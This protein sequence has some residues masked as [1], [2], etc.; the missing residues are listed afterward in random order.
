MKLKYTVQAISSAIVSGLSESAGKPHG[1]TTRPELPGTKR[2]ASELDGP[3]DLVEKSVDSTNASQLAKHFRHDSPFHWEIEPAVNIDDSTNE[4]EVQGECSDSVEASAARWQASEELSTFLG[5]TRTPLSKSDKR[6][7]VKDYP[8]PNL[9]APFTPR[10]DSY[11][12]GLMGGLTGPE[13][14]LREIQDKVLDIVGPLRT[15]HEHLLDKL[16]TPSSII[17]FSRE[18]GTGLMAI[19]Q[20]SIQ[21]AKHASATISQ[22]HRVGV[23]SKSVQKGQKQLLKLRKWG[24]SFFGPPLHM[25]APTWHVQ[26]HGATYDVGPAKDIGKPDPILFNPREGAFSH[27]QAKPQ[28]T[29]EQS[30]ERPSK[31]L[32]VHLE[33]ISLGVCRSPIRAGQCTQVI[34]QTRETRCG[35]PLEL[36]DLFCYIS[37]RPSHPSIFRAVCQTPPGNSYESPREFGVYHQTKKVCFNSSADNRIPGY[38]RGLRQNKHS[39]SALDGQ[40]GYNYIHQQNEGN[41]ILC[42]RLSVLQLLAVVSSEADNS[43]CYSHPRDPECDC[44]QGIQV[45]PGLLRLEALPSSVPDPSE[46]LG[47]SGTRPVCV[48]VDKP[49]TSLCELETR[50]PCRSSGCLL[51]SM[52]HGQE[53]CLL[54]LLSSRQVPQS[55]SETTSPISCTGSTSVEISTL[56]SPLAGSFRRLASPYS[57]VSQSFNPGGSVPPSDPPPTGR[58]AYL[59]QQFEEE[60]FSCQARELLSAAWRKNTSDQYASAWRKWTSW[61]SLRKINSVSVS[62]NNINNFLASEF[63]QGK[64]YQ[65]LNVY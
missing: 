9:D 43:V 23:L 28:P 3:R 36:G 14:K 37:G 45:S 63:L 25:D 49:V 15:A 57:P 54:P 56:V 7:M 8:R 1:S 22:K 10:L 32:K 44:R 65:T 48:S 27:P 38:V 33:E 20:R 5:T 60:G 11:L 50:P 29:S 61:C 17:Q 47:P 59:W 46:P 18:E 64:Q 13:A 41:Q 31:I 2:S 58:M 26:G 34:H 39:H 21:L 35:N 19:I 12:P 42:P 62:L 6:Q 40:F 53:L 55:S 24:N 16:D 51:P 4:S 52:E 30:L